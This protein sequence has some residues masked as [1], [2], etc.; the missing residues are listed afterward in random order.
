METSPAGPIKNTVGQKQAEEIVQRK[1]SQD[2]VHHALCKQSKDIIHQETTEETLKVI[3]RYTHQRS[4]RTTWLAATR[5]NPRAAAF[6][7]TMRILHS[8]S[9]SK[10]AI[11]ASLAP[12]V[13]DPSSRVKLNLHGLGKAV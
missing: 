8:G 10:V 6:R 4:R 13:I 2:T 3:F 11:A 1:Q 7:L 5:F 9:P 12:T